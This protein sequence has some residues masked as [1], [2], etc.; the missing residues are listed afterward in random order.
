MSHQ[1]INK[2][3]TDTTNRE[4][5]CFIF[6][7]VAVKTDNTITKFSWSSQLEERSGFCLLSEMMFCSC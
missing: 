1:T 7:V 3:F 5:F 2:I 4:E 6:I